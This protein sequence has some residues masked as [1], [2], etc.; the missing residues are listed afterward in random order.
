M[1]IT[2]R[3]EH[4]KLIAEA[5]ET[6]A[7]R[8]SNDVIDRALELLQ[9]EESS[10]GEDRTEISAK[11]ERALAQFENGEFY[12]SEQFRSNMAQ[13]KAKWLGERQRQP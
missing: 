7:Y 6:G 11:I 5:I 2:L 4:E 8:D 13:R 3:P 9:S 12:T 10:L 1:T